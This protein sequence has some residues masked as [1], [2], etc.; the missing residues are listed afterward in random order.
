MSQA[1]L[2]A[3]DQHKA[4]LSPEVYKKVRDNIDKIPA[5]VEKEMLVQLQN[6]AHLEK[7]ID[8]YEDQRVEVLSQAAKKFME[9]ENKYQD[10]FKNALK[11]AEAEEKKASADKIDKL[12]ED[13]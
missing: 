5:D 12:I 10:G 8:E 13:L 7:L 9:V 1:L 4:H 11:S 2:S 6:A 3:L